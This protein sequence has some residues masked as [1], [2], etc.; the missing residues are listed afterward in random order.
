VPPGTLAESDHR[1]SDLLCSPTIYRSD[2]A[3][4][5]SSR[6]DTVARR[7]DDTSP[8]DRTVPATFNVGK[9]RFAPCALWHT[10]WVRILPPNLSHG[11]LRSFVCIFRMVEPAMGSATDALS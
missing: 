10:F 1:S 2:V 5:A 8:L 3:R 11:Q 9:P 4:L 7:I 6:K